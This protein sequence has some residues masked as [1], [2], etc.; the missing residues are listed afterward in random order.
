MATALNRLSGV[1]GVSVL[2]VTHSPVIINAANNVSFVV[3][4]AAKAE[5]LHDAVASMSDAVLA[6]RNLTPARE[7]LLGW[8]ADRAAGSERRV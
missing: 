8:L 2:I 4:G 1:A 3:S 7:P 6:Y 5:R